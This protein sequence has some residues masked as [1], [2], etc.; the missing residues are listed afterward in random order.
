[1]VKFFE[2][3]HPFELECGT[4]LPGLRLAYHTFGQL[5]PE[6]NNVVWVCHALTANSDVYEWWPG[7]FGPNDFFNPGEHFMVCVNMPGSCYGSTHP[8]TLNPETGEP[9]YHDFP[10]IT[11]RDMVKAYQLLKHHL[12]I[13]NIQV[14]IGGSM[15]G[16]QAMEWAIEKPEEITHLVLI[17]TNAVHSPWGIAWNESQR[18]AIRA[19]S[20]Y[21]TR[22]KDAGQAGL[23]AARAIALLSYRHYDAYKIKQTDTDN[24]RLYN[25][26]ASSY[27]QYQGEKLA[28]R[29]DAFSYLTLTHA[30]DSHNVSRNRS[31]LAEALGKIK[32]KTIII[33]IRSDVLFPPVEQEILAEYIPQSTL[34]FI[35]S[36]YGHDGFLLETK[37][38]TTILKQEIIWPFNSLSV[39]SDSA[40]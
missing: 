21:S 28:Q 10:L 13:E 4:V 17:A 30:M 29:F 2:Y 31:S 34:H 18:I 38:L 36:D 3:R 24:T 23:K 9:Y 6:K 20:S 5:N 14:M 40:V 16:Q 35:E 37:Q 11:I 27:Q 25:F 26:Q 33:G 8:L 22:K 15:G 39:Y 19:D 1:M 7:L 32:A 12:G